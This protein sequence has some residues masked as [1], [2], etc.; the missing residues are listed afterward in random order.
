MKDECP[1]DYLNEELSLSTVE[2]LHTCLR[3]LT[4]LAFRRRVTD[5]L[6]RE[7]T[8]QLDYARKLVDGLI[9]TE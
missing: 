2:A 4:R 6:K 3:L 5:Q 9:E 7:L 1:T 8:N